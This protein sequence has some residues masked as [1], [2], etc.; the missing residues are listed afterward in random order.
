MV[1][2]EEDIGG[3]DEEEK[4]E[5]GLVIGWDGSVG[6]FGKRWEDWGINDEV[7]LIMKCIDCY[8]EEY[9]VFVGVL[10]KIFIW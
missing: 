2:F 3:E 5:R 4:W 1:C 7:M 8:I 10:D 9:W 6:G